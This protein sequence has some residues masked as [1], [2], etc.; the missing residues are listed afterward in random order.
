MK[1]LLRADLLRLF[2]SR[3]YIILLILLLFYVR[4]ANLLGFSYL[5]F[6][7]SLTDGA[8][9]FS[10]LGNNLFRIFVAAF[11]AYYFCKNL[12]AGQIQIKVRAGHSR[13]RIAVSL[14]MAYLI[15]QTAVFFVSYTFNAVLL[16]LRVQSP[17]AT[18]TISVGLPYQ[19][20]IT[21]GTPSGVTAAGIGRELLLTVPCLL[22]LIALCFFA[23]AC[24]K[25][26]L[27]TILIVGI[28]LGLAFHSA[29]DA[30]I[31][32]PT[33]YIPDPDFNYDEALRDDMTAE[34]IQEVLD[35]V[36]LVENPDYPD[37]VRIAFTRLR[38]AL[39]PVYG[40]YLLQDWLFYRDDEPR[41]DL[42]DVPI[43]QDCIVNAACSYAESIVLTALGL[44]N[45]RKKEFT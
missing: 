2:K 15:G 3:D 34:E 41:R 16:V 29:D 20:S 30:I 7:N 37:P 28:C 21:V 24:T 38:N 39:N 35:S 45:F 27:K 1:T 32:N 17:A 40:W 6:G 13:T 5:F 42:S 18:Q 9:I 12:S 31:N 26:Y 4:L 19:E 11:A 22:A 43:P 44:L 14:L 33:Q 8:E 23:S 36:P 10:G 25:G